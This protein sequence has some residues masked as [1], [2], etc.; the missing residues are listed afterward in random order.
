MNYTNTSN[1][2]IKL[3]KKLQ[4]KKYREK[5]KLFLVEGEHLVKEA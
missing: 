5:E 4:T 1:P 2:K 3:L